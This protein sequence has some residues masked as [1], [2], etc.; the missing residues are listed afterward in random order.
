MKIL[1]NDNFK[2]DEISENETRKR[3]I[4]VELKLAGWEFN[5]DIIE[6]EKV[7]GMPNKSG[8]W[9]YRLCFIWR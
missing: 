4:D 8:S 5:K 1:I 2:I 7:I 3:F 6:E 9:V